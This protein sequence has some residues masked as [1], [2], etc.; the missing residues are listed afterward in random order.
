[1]FVAVAYS[2][3]VQ[4]PVVGK[5]RLKMN[6]ITT[7]K[8]S[9]ETLERIKKIGNMGESYEDVIK[10]LIDEHIKIKKR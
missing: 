4:I 5:R 2:I 9:K 7:I 1:M 10:M 3:W 6:K 8:L